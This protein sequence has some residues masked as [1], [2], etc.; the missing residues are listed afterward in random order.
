MAF[1]RIPAE[2][3]QHVLGGITPDGGG[4]DLFFITPDGGGADLFF[5]TPD[6]GGADLFK[7]KTRN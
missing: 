6:G 3:L 5:I 2:M 4:A 7:T 1:K